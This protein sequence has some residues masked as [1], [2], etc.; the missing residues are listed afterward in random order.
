MPIRE[1]DPVKNDGGF[2]TA[3]R[4]FTIGL[5]LCMM[6]KYFVM[7]NHAKMSVS[8]AMAEDDVEPGQAVIIRKEELSDTAALRC[9][10]LSAK[11]LA[12]I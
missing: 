1:T 2:L 8:P 7:H 11:C 12:S 9:R 5:C 6:F 4:N 10:C 3:T